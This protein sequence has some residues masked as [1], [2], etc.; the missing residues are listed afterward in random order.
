MLDEPGHDNAQFSEDILWEVETSEIPIIVQPENTTSPFNDYQHVTI[1]IEHEEEGMFSC[2]PQTFK[3]DRNPQNFSGNGRPSQVVGKMI[4][5]IGDSPE[6]KYFE[7]I[8]KIKTIPMATK[9]HFNKF[10]LLRN[11]LRREPETTDSCCCDES[12]DAN[13]NP[14]VQTIKTKQVH[15]TIEDFNSYMDGINFSNCEMCVRGFLRPI[16]LEE[17]LEKHLEDIFC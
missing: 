9:Y 2:I 8:P 1:P 16:E 17:H 6:P 3:S 11:N 14:S 7:Q 12:Y 15:G 13:R 5:G 4:Y 10:D